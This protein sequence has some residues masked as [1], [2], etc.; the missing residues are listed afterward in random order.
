MKMSVPKFIVI[1]L[2]L[3][4]VFPVNN[5]AVMS[6]EGKPKDQD[7]PS[8]RAAVS[9]V[10]ADDF[11]PATVNFEVSVKPNNA[12]GEVEKPRVTATF[13]GTTVKGDK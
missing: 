5:S 9:F 4:A 7:N 12:P 13:S 8:P 11:T 6:Q 10:F 3:T 2:L 1:A